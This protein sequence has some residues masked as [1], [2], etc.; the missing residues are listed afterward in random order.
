MKNTRKPTDKFTHPQLCFRVSVTHGQARSVQHIQRHSQRQVTSHKF[1]YRMLLCSILLLLIVFTLYYT[2]V[3]KLNF[4]SGTQCIGK[5]TADLRFGNTHS[6]GHP[7]GGLR[8]IPWGEEG[9]T[10]FLVNTVLEI[11][12]SMLRHNKSIRKKENRHN[13]NKDN[14]MCGKKNLKPSESTH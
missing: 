11:I 8:N 13:L 5:N 9:T 1:Y 12:A 7:L 3:Y 2:C 14:M 10:V 6:F 4:T